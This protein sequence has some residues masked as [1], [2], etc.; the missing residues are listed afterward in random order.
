M[1][2]NPPLDEWLFLIG[3]W[4]GGSK[5]QFDEEGEIQSV[6]EFSLE[7]GGFSIMSKT[8]SWNQGRLIH[9][10][11][12]F[13]FFDVLNKVFRRKT[14]FSYGFVNNEVEYQRS[15]S[16]IRFEVTSEPLPKQFK[17]MHWRSYIKKISD[18]E[19][20]FGLE[21]AK[22]GEDFQLYGESILNKVS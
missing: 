21:Q 22:K 2:D 3:K 10:S 14:L 1:N 19:I 9:S 13:M 6:A 17:K 20:A 12:S 16:E 4:E 15:D 5:D 7:L 11:L 8:E 18:T